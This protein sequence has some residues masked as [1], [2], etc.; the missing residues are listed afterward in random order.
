MLL[1]I[2]LPR[3]ESSCLSDVIPGGQGQLGDLTTLGADIREL[4][5]I[6]QPTVNLQTG[7]IVVKTLPAVSQDCFIFPWSWHTANSLPLRTNK[8]RVPQCFASAWKAS[9]AGNW[10]CQTWICSPAG[11]WA[12]SPFTC[13]IGTCVW[14]RKI[15]MELSLMLCNSRWSLLLAVRQLWS[16]GDWLSWEFLF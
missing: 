4:P 10:N 8:F 14:I 3:C 7:C 15:F 1:G 16:P 13:T 11:A 6:L 9:A 12:V 5:S 2:L